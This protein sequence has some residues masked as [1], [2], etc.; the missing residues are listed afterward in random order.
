ME[1]DDHTPQNVLHTDPQ[2]RR[3]KTWRVFTMS[4]LF[5]AYTCLYFAFSILSVTT[6]LIMRDLRFDEKQFGLIITISR[7]IRFIPKMTGGYVVDIIGGKHMFI[8]GEIIAG[9]FTI[10]F[11]VPLFG[12]P[13]WFLITCFCIQQ[14]GT[15]WPWPSL[16]KMCSNWI[17]YKHTGRVMSVMSLSYLFGA[18]FIG[19]IL[20][21]LIK[22]GFGWRFVYYVSGSILLLSGITAIVFLKN[23]PSQIGLTYEPQVN[24]DN[25]VGEHGTTSGFSSVREFFTLS[26][27]PFLTSLSFWCLVIWYMALTFV[28]YVFTDWFAIYMSEQIHVNDFIASLSTISF[29][30]FGGIGAVIMGYIN[31]RYSTTTRNLFMI[32]F[33]VLLVVFMVLLVLLNIFVE[34]PGPD[35]PQSILSYLPVLALSLIGFCTTAPS[36][37]TAAIS[38]NFGARRISATHSSLLDGM[39]TIMTM[40]SGTVGGALLDKSKEGWTKLF[41]V[42]S[43]CS[44]FI[45]IT[46]VLLIFVERLEHRK[47]EQNNVNINNNEHDLLMEENTTV[48]E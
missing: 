41:I 6:P 44:L 26:C 24:P 33:E 48:N 22:L 29:P 17:D 7:A 43:A 18:S 21:G 39:G 13:L 11:A 19:L 4:F 27:L 10:L 28:R 47:K 40:L 30:L 1:Q 38:I 35:D 8:I 32:G 37:I 3:F 31:D 9:V 25:A 16:L 15:V 36:S 23:S 2:E 20:S 14:I 45:V 46:N 34:F 5:C 42:L 12:S